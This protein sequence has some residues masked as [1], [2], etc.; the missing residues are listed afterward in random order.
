MTRLWLSMLLL[1]CG[2]LGAPASGRQA[3]DT[4]RTL[5]ARE[6]RAPGALTIRAVQGTA[7]GPVVA[8]ADVEVEYFKGNNRLSHVTAKLDGS[9]RLIIDDVPSGTRPLVRIRYDGVW[10]QD[11][12]P[13]MEAALG[14]TSMD[15]TVYATTE[16]APAWRIVERTITIV[17]QD[18]GLTV[19]EAIIAE[20]PSDR[21]WLGGTPD[22]RGQRPTVILGLPEN[23]AGIELESG[24]HGW[25]CTAFADRMLAIQMPLM[26][27]RTAFSF[28]YQVR[29]VGG[30]AELRWAAPVRSGRTVFILP[31][32]AAVGETVNVVAGA[33]RLRDERAR[34]YQATDLGPGEEAGI[35]LTGLVTAS[36]VLTTS[37]LAGS[38]KVVIVLGSGLVLLISAGLVFRRSLRAP[39]PAH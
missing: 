9:G 3:S 22:T 12:G 13:E 30:R 14:P 19:S 1:C 21:T 10:Y 31:D 32:D 39:G 4:G 28:S 33:P 20:N 16:V 8:A 37:E 6:P 2:A 36:D 25:C 35:V 18:S 26:P 23:A 5:D 7:G 11:V 34:I 17:R 24:F 27:G 38:A 15:V 29:P